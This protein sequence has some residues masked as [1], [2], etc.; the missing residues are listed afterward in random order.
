MFSYGILQMTSIL[1]QV[2]LFLGVTYNKCAMYKFTI[3]Q[4][5]A[6][7][8]VLKELMSLVVV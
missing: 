2:T 1:L 4:I 8:N 6:P 5:G 7:N 3:H